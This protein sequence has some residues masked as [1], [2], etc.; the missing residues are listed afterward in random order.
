MILERRMLAS[1][2]R[3]ALG[4]SANIHIHFSIGKAAVEPLRKTQITTRVTGGR[5]IYFVRAQGG[6]EAMFAVLRTV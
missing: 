6:N 3:F 2:L 1:I 5:S 4:S